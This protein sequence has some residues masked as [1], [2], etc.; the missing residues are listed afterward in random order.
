MSGGAQM[1]NGHGNGNG[2][3]INGR[4]KGDSQGDEMNEKAD[5]SMSDVGSGLISNEF[6]VEVSVTNLEKP[7]WT[8][9]YEL[10]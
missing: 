5:A 3:G 4:I 7:C 10:V 8:S 2:N 6:Q 1:T 9:L